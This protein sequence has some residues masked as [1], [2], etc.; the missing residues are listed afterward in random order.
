MN[1]QETVVQRQT[2]KRTGK[3]RFDSLRSSAR[4]R[5]QQTPQIR[6]KSAAEMKGHLRCRLWE[7]PEGR[8][9]ESEKILPLRANRFEQTW[10]EDRDKYSLER[11][12]KNRWGQ[13]RNK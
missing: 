9:K 4:Y 1:Y 2:Y 8:G 13:G 3:T 5:N 11:K 12:Q 10:K 7:R 6:G